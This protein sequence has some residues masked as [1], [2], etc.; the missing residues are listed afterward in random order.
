[1]RKEGPLSRRTKLKQEEVK[2]PQAPHRRIRGED[3]PPD[4]RP[5]TNIDNVHE[6]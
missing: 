5:Q 4:T 2:T 6:V 3:S 1:M